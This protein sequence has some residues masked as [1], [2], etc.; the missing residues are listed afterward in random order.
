MRTAIDTIRNKL[1][2]TKIMLHFGGLTSAEWFFGKV[3]SLNYDYMGISYYP[4]WHGNNLDNLKN[5]I[6]YLSQTYN[7]KVLIA[8]TAYP[9]TLG[10]NDWTNNIVG[11]QN[12]LIPGFEA[13]N[14][15]Q[16]NY[17]TRLVV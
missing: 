10:W 15:G 3:Q 11:L 14:D 13:T 1:P 2:K 17:I 5:K 4:V 9:F 16:K 6:N 8:E 7:K 12:Q